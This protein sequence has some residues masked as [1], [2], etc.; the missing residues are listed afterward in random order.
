M[1]TN[2]LVKDIIKKEKMILKLKKE[3]EMEKNI[4]GMI[5]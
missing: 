5:N 4:I 1:E 2:G 3:K